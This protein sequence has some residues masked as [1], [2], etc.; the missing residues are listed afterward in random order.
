MK[1]Y[2]TTKLAL[3]LAVQ[4]EMEGMKAENVNRA[5]ENWSMAYRDE[6]FGM[7]ADRFKELSKLPDYISSGKEQRKSESKSSGLGYIVSNIE[8]IN[9][10]LSMVGY[11]TNTGIKKQVKAGDFYD[12][13]C[14]YCLSEQITPVSN[15]K[16][17]Y[18]LAGL[19]FL[20]VRKNDGI[21]YA[22]HST[23]V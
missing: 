7:V 3:I 9:Q 17:A 20:K 16:F 8:S 10:Y 14:A 1:F 5:Q 21:Y 2:N 6:D 23:G 15:V 22:V 18:R 12:L 4:S 13:Y 19:G 11:N